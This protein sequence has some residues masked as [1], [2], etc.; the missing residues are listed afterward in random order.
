MGNPYS[1]DCIKII[2]TGDSIFN[3]CNWIGYVDDYAAQR[4]GSTT[5]DHCYSAAGLKIWACFGFSF[6]VVLNWGPSS[7]E[8]HTPPN[9]GAC[10][11]Y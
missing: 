10:K 7:I 11:V 3:N 9:S 5:K 6:V 1:R 4:P 2:E 8:A